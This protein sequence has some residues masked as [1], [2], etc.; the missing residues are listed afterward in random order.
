M[1]KNPESTRTLFSMGK[2]RSS[3]M[4]YIVITISFLILYVTGFIITVRRQ[5]LD[6]IT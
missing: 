6:T 1:K 4:A 2:P 5:V 3:R